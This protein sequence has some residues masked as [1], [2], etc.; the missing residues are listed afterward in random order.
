LLGVACLGVGVGFG[1]SVL[2]QADTANE[3]C[4]QNLC[5]SQRGV[6]AAQTAATQATFA[7]VGVAA[8]AA[9]MVTGA[10][11]WI[12]GARESAP[13]S[14]RA[15]VEMSVAPLASASELA[16]ALSGRW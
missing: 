16:M 7:T 9:L 2:K 6:D 8:G 3:L 10:V 11:F 13:S 12:A 15:T 5:T 4:D 14:E 1:I